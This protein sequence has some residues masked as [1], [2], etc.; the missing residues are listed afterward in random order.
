MADVLHEL[1]IGSEHSM[2]DWNNFL[3]ASYFANNPVQI[4][5][6]GDKAEI[7]EIHFPEENTI[8]RE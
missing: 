6:T 5:D 4:G 2:V 8:E 7:D 1:Q 3:A